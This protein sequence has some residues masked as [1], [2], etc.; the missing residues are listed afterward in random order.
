MKIL[1]L[2][3][4]LPDDIQSM[5]R[6]ATMLETGLPQFG[7]QVR[8][9]RPQPGLG[10]FKPS[11]TGVG[12]WLGY[13]DKF[14]LFPKKLRQEISWADVVHICDH[15]NAVYTKYLQNVP[16]VVTCNDL[17][18][19]RSALGE[20]PENQT[21]WTGR[22]LQKMILNGLNQAQRVA[23]ISEQTRQDLLRLS[24][25]KVSAISLIYMG[26]NYVYTPMRKTE[27]QQYLDNLGI[28]NNSRFILHVGGNAWYKN[29]IGVLS[30]FYYLTQKQLQPYCYL[31]MVGQSFTS[32]MRQYIKTHDLRQKVIELVGVDNEDLRALYSSATALLFPSLQEGFGWPIIEA[33]ACGCPVIT[34]NRPPMTEV[35]GEA[36][37][38]IEPN[39][40][41]KAAETIAGCLPILESFKQK[42]ILNAQYFNPEKMI[43]SYIQLYQDIIFDSKKSSKWVKLSKN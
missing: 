36:A 1:L 16:H 40:P 26:L 25:L 17:L 8:V 23:C 15:S 22:Q 30:I 38:Y 24:S 33:Q 13:I 31:I 11:P 37:I 29:R 27:A 42:G 39:L 35:G 41:E 19:I 7:H 4:Y 2:A 32:E 10:R 43:F 21:R 9:I 18:A 3:N 14:I 6:F 12:K 34:S 28:P 5:Q 20:I